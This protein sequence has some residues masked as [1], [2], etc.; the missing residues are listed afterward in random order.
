PV[1]DIFITTALYDDPAEGPT[2]LHFST[3]M[4]A[5]GVRV[6]DNWRTLG[7]RASG[8]NDVVLDGVFVP[9]EAVASRRPKGAWVPYFNVASAVAL[10]AVL[11]VYLGVAEAARD[12][13]L[14]QIGRRR[15]DVDVWYV[16]GEMENALTAGQLA[17][18]SIVDICGDYAFLPEV[19]TS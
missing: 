19:S 7:M 8:S 3:A 18:Q 5:A 1:G 4:K 9:D 11:S 16:V 6:L 15:D 10:P 12:L 13:A 2:V 17:V 14:A